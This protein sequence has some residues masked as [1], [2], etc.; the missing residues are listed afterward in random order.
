MADFGA[1]DAFLE[2]LTGESN[3]AN[4]YNVDRS[5]EMPVAPE[6][7]H[8]ESG[9]SP[10]A[11][12]HDDDDDYDPSGLVTEAKPPSKSTPSPQNGG[13]AKSLRKGGFLIESDDEAD[14]EGNA[15]PAANG[16]G[17]ADAQRSATGTPVAAFT[18][19]EAHVSVPSDQNLSQAITSTNPPISNPSSNRAVHPV[20][21][22]AGAEAAA[23]GDSTAR[24]PTDLVGILEARIQEDPRGD[25]EAWLTLLH[26]H[27]SHDRFDHVRNVYNR[28]FQYFPTAVSCSRVDWSALTMAGPPTALVLGHG[29]FPKRIG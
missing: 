7:D 17:G 25:V 8:R 6:P 13:V 29:A 10:A 27:Q 12:A 5:A 28:F 1:E 16:I 9:D 4:E 15:A 14:G 23:A 26:E 19:A 20:A 3:V 24:D 21:S 22:R 11:P 18:S 2:A